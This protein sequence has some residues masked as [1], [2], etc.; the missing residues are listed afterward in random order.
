[1]P[2]HQKNIKRGTSWDTVYLFAVFAHA[3]FPFPVPNCIFE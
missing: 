3:P 2:V 1:M